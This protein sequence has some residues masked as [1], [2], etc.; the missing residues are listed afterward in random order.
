MKISSW[1]KMYLSYKF[2]HS[3]IILIKY[4]RILKKRLMSKGVGKYASNQSYLYSILPFLRTIYIYINIYIRSLF[5]INSQAIQT[6]LTSVLEYLVLIGNIYI[7]IYIYIYIYANSLN[8]GYLVPFPTT[9]N[10]PLESSIT[11]Q[12]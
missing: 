9:I 2:S 3:K 1:I 7:C 11:T 6:L 12:D 4:F 10:M 8:T 5:G